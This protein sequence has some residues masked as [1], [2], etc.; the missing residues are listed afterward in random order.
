MR[1]LLKRRLDLW[2]PSYVVG[3]LERR[4]LR[5][6]R[7]RALTHVLFMVC[8]HYEPQHGVRSPQQARARLRAWHEGYRHLQQ[9]CFARFGLRPLHSWFYPPHHG[10]E[11]FAPLAH[12]AFDG[13]GEVE[14]H[15]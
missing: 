7:S 15:F 10:S 4:R 9:E 3:A 13:L 14:L 8:D 2:L 1:R 11:H 5:R 12:M 6:W